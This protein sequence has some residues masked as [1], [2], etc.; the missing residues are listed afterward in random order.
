[1]AVVGSGG[2]ADA[3]ASKLGTAVQAFDSP[4]PTGLDGVV[5]VFDEPTETVFADVD[6]PLWHRLAHEPVRR[7]MSTLRSAW[8]ALRA[9]GGRI[10]V[11]LPTLG[12]PGSAHL[13]PYTTA[14]E[15]IRAMTKSAARQWSGHGVTANMVAVP[16]HLIAPSL[17]SL[18]AHLTAPAV[19][20]PATLLDDVAQTTTFLLRRDIDHLVGQ[21][22]VV[23]GG[24]VMLP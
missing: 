2:F 24:S 22:L 18:A 9:S 7:T 4:L 23:D 15:G 11:V 10:V 8:S 17:D 13:V 1:M 14:V 21:T 20:N 19:E 3:L 12:L 16:L 5:V 6:E